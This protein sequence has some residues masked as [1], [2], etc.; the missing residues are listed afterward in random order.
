MFD[1]PF[2]G[3]KIPK[4]GINIVVLGAEDVKSQKTSPDIWKVKAQKEQNCSSIAQTTTADN[5]GHPHGPHGNTTATFSP[6]PNMTKFHPDP[7]AMKMVKLFK[8]N[9]RAGNKPVA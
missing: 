6:W 3:A 9:C 5:K 8:W 2:C 1:N 7:D 4:F